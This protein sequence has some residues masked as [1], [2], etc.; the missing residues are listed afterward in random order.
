[1]NKDILIGYWSCYCG[2]NFYQDLCGK[3][4]YIR[5]VDLLWLNTPVWFWPVFGAAGLALYL[6]LDLREILKRR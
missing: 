6:Y 1:M 3:Q 5:R 4:E 2:M